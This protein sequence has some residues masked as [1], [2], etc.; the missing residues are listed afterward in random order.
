MAVSSMMHITTKT[1]GISKSKFYK[2]HK[3]L[4]GISNFHQMLAKFEERRY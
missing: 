2:L 4:F 3:G 1:F